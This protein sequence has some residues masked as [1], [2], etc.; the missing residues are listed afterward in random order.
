MK[1]ST[2]NYVSVILVPLVLGIII[3]W[4]VYATLSG[5]PIPLIHGPRAALISMLIIGLAMC[6]P[7]IF[8]VSNSGRW[9][10]PVAIVGYLL[11][12]IILLVIAS[13]FTGWK[14]PL[15]RG[16]TQAIIAVAVLM[17]VKYLI[18][19]TGILLHVL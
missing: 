5:K 13:A 1:V 3:A 14:L 15:I 19:I 4:I 11:G 16:D 9:F 10:S 6:A 18:G 2:M 17:A 7:G 12:A 8:Q